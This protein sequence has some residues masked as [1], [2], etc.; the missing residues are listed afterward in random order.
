MV[1]DYDAQAFH[2]DFFGL[3]PGDR[4][5][6]DRRGNDH[7]RSKH[8]CPLIRQQTTEIKNKNLACTAISSREG[9]LCG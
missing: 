7:S 8:D 9:S 6:G 3:R 5:Y 4:R 2:L 1:G